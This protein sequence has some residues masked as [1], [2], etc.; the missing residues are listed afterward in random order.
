MYAE[1]GDKHPG[2]DCFVFKREVYPHYKLGATCLGIPW[3]DSVLIWNVAC[4]AQ[5]FSV[6]RKLHV[7]FHIGDSQ[8]WL[9]EKY[10][11]YY[12]YN[13]EEARKVLQALEQIHGPL[14]EIRAFTRNALGV[15]FQK[16]RLSDDGTAEAQ[17]KRLKKGI[18]RRLRL[19]RAI[20][21][22]R[23]RNSR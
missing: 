23:K 18:E 8:T 16:Q 20:E 6:F 10:T 2:F 17:L 4:H 14:E 1:A 5:N 13:K 21:E 22:D 9:E 15:E 11:D 19:Q 7:S 12:V 3:I